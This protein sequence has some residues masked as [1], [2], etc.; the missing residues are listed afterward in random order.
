MFIKY[1]WV[2]LLKGERTSSLSC[3][4]KI[5]KWNVVGLQGGL[6]SLIIN[7]PIYLTSIII[8]DLFCMEALKRSLIERLYEI[9]EGNERNFPINEMVFK[10]IILLFNT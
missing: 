7:Q 6:L 8:G 3:S 5:A 2:F 1:Y 9:K 10:F 4:D